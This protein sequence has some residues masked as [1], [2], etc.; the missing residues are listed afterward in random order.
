MPEADWQALWAYMDAHGFRQVFCGHTHVPFMRTH[1]DRLVCNLGSAGAPLDGD[2]RACWVSFEP[3]AS[4]ATLHRVAYD[5][6]ATH[7]LID[8]NPDYYDFQT[9]GFV[10][11]YKKW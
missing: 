8:A 1:A 9:P 2:P 11:A 3:G 5:V 10:A 4:V 6:A 7:A